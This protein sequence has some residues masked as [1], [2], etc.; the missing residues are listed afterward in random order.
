[1]RFLLRLVVEAAPRCPDRSATRYGTTPHPKVGVT[2][3]VS[4][5]R[6]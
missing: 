1:M 2:G 5:T 3:L 4:V 6:Q